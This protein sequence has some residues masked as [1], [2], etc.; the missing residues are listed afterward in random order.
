MLLRRKTFALF[1]LNVPL[2]Q[3]PVHLI[4][5][6]EENLNKPG[7]CIVS[8]RGSFPWKW[9]APTVVMPFFGRRVRK[10]RFLFFFPKKV[11]SLRT[12]GNTGTDGNCLLQII[13]DVEY[14]THMTDHL[15]KSGLFF[16]LPPVIKHYSLLQSDIDDVSNAN[17][18]LNVT[19]R[20]KKQR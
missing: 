19:S 15:N 7:S 4:D 2:T 20:G 3:T 5:I 14:V 13:S 18:F 17:I 11:V 16:F 10:R 6:V 8:C 1:L 12:D 9:S